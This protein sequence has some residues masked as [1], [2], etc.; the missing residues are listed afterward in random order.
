VRLEDFRMEDGDK[1]KKI[2]KWTII[3]VLSVVIIVFGTLLIISMGK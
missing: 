1:K 2:I 3:G